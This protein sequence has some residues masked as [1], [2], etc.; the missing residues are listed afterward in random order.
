MT[1]KGG[2]NLELA[3]QKKTGPRVSCLNKWLTALFFCPQLPAAQ[4]GAG[5]TRM[6]TPIHSP[7]K[8][9]SLDGPGKRPT[10]VRKH[11]GQRVLEPGYNARSSMGHPAKG[12]VR[13][14]NEQG[15]LQQC[16]SNT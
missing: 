8:Q 15:P 14:E 7:C 3:E 5:H 6:W 13:T 16:F 12:A 2:S 9:L 11:S 1:Q 10:R 4:Q